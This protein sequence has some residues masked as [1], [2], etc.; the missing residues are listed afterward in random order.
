MKVKLLQHSDIDV[1]DLAISK[2]WDMPNKGETHKLKRMNRVIN[3]NHHESVSEHYNLTWDVEGISRALLQ[4]LSRHRVGTSL[5][6]RSSRYTLNRLKDLPSFEGKNYSKAMNY[7]VMTGDIAV[8]NR[9]IAALNLLQEVVKKGISN[10]FTKY[11]MPESFKT[12]LVLTMNIRSLKHF[13]MLRSSPAALWE[14]QQLAEALY[15]SIP[16]NVKFLIKEPKDDKV[17]NESN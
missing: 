8:D 11:A 16:E 15:N 14:I 9:S 7:L 1:I 4:E 3:Q 5:S 13:Y 6:V 12:G 17:S 2:C 10:D